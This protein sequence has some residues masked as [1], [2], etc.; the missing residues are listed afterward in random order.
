ML[1]SITNS[2]NVDSTQPSLRAKQVQSTQAMSLVLNVPIAVLLVFVW[3][4]SPVWCG[5]SLNARL[6]AVIR[7]EL[8][9]N[10]EISIQV[11]DLETGR[12]L[13]EKNPDLPLIPAS[14]MKVA[15][16]SAALR[17]LNPD[18]VFVTEV[19]VD[20]QRGAKVGNIY[21]KGSGDPYL[22]TEE[23]FRLTRLVK[24]QGLDEVGGDIIVDDSYFIPGKPM[25]ENEKLGSRAYHAPYSALSLNF[26]AIKIIVHPGPKP[27]EPATVTTDPLSEYAVIKSAIKTVKGNKPVHMEI[28]K[29]TAEDGKEI[30]TLEGSIGVDATVKGRYVNVGGPDLYTGEVF[31]EFLLREGVKVE[32]KVRRGKVPSTATSFLEFHSR[33]LGMI[34]YGLNK[35]SN[36]FMAE[37]ISLALGAHVHGSPGTREKGLAVIRKHLL[38]CGVDEGSFSLSEASGLSRNN[39]LSAS[40]LV[41]VLLTAARDFSYN[42]E[43]IASL[44]VSGIDG[45]LKEKFTDTAVRRRLRA[46]TGTLKGITALAGYGM[47]VDGKPFVFAVLVN[48]MQKGTG[49]I[50]YG[51]KIMRAIL[52]IPL[53]A[54]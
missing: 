19:L 54:R 6:E 41:R 22:V 11:A 31:K 34:I 42:S 45:T 21:L 2:V 4:V 26:N 16:S 14:T 48:S 30:I 7:K 10:F 35:F 25:D 33:P 38:S 12:V 3:F 37:Q 20:G 24:D 32:G 9:P 29:E 47:S 53:G 50:D 17:F 5:Q 8:P 51:E 44:G 40:A 43:F 1:R 28:I 39:R 13:M 18:F 49:F 36:N 46:K 27:G 23:L 52:D 15:T